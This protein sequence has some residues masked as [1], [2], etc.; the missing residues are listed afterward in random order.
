[1]QALVRTGPRVRVGDLDF[2]GNR[3]TRESVLQR[4][5]SLHEGDWLE[6]LK[7]EQGR[8]RL[9]RLGVFDSVDL[10][11]EKVDEQTRNIV[12]ELKEGKRVD[13]HLLF[14]YGSYELLR[15]GVQVEQYNLFGLAHRQQLKLTESFK[16][17]SADY[18][19]TMPELFGENIDVF[20]N[21]SGLKRQEIS[22]TRLE[23]GG[24]AGLR[25]YLQDIKTDI[26]LRYSYQ[27]LEAQDVD[28]SLAEEGPENSQAAAI[29][30][31][32]NHDQRDNPLYPRRGYKIFDTIEL[33]SDYLGGDVS[34]QRIDFNASLHVP[35]SDSQWLH[36][37]LSHGVISTLDGTSEELPFNR[38]FFP[39]GENTVRGFQQGEAAPRDSDGNIVGA[40][41]YLLGNFEFEQGLTPKWALVTFVDAVGF[42]R[43]L[44]DYPQD[45][46]LV[47]VGGGL[48]WK[49]FV[50]PV[51]LEYGHNLNPRRRD[52]SGT[53]H[54]SLGFPF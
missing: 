45:E 21:A 16:S 17:T 11:Y 27:I 43:D 41:T 48:R 13:V 51:R 6:R 40:E 4:R 32:L 37:G 46:T 52:P 9:S 44:K 22:F 20:F 1:L 24:A 7:A 49:T 3:R 14:G 50:G 28:A 23:Y 47:S 31:D 19:Y 38:R 29:I 33:A 30:T 12:Y 36:F 34:Y 26:S 10:K 15:G 35:V 25:K 5:V 8:Y 2:T 53:I 39:G 42:A 18:T 54:F